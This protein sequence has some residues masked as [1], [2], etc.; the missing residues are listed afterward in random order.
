[1]NT[2]PAAGGKSPGIGDAHDSPQAKDEGSAPDLVFG[3]PDEK[4][5]V[6]GLSGD[7]IL[8]NALPSA[9]EVRKR[10]EAEATIR[11]LGGNEALGQRAA[12]ISDLGH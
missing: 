1:M 10:L 12:D 2:S 6:A 11:R 8:G 4:S 5:L 3:R 7:W 9:D